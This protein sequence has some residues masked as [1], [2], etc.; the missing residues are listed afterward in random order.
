[1]RQKHHEQTGKHNYVSA[2]SSQNSSATPAGKYMQRSS[3]SYEVSNKGYRS[4]VQSQNIFRINPDNYLS[5]SQG[6]FKEIE[7]DDMSDD[8]ND[9]NNTQIKL[10][11]KHETSRQ[12]SQ[13]NKEDIKKAC[14]LQLINTSRNDDNRNCD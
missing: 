9:N 5:I 12:Q 13:Q 3:S 8:N 4:K 2:T 14:R 11:D 10:V 6:L 1:V 7:D